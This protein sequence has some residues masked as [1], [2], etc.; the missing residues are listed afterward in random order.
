VQEVL[1]LH[2][3]G[4]D[5]SEIAQLLD[6]TKTQVTTIIA[7]SAEVE[8]LIALP[9][10]PDVVPAAFNLASPPN[11]AWFRP[12]PGGFNTGISTRGPIAFFVVPLAVTFFAGSLYALVKHP[13]DNLLIVFLFSLAML[14]VAAMTAAGQVRVT[15][16]GDKLTI[17]T[18]VGP[19]GFTQTHQ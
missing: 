16:D 13:S 5:P 4:K 10:C 19:L 3:A 7:H 18:G 9:E 14:F 2:N 17:F 8:R 12:L 15:R 1:R 6:L 11:G